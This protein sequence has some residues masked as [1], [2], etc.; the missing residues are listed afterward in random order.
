MSVTRAQA[1]LRAADAAAAT[2]PGSDDKDLHWLVN[3]NMLTGL[4]NRMRFY[5]DV[6]TVILVLLACP[7]LCDHL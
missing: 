1:S 4:A 7:K 2:G 5:R 3:F 6:E